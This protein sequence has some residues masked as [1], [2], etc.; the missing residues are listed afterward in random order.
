MNINLHIPDL[1]N[2][3]LCQICKGHV[4]FYDL[5]A[6]IPVNGAPAHRSSFEADS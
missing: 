6:G 4:S 2:L 5:C 3:V 1:R